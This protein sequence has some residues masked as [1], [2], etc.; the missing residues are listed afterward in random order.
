M[1]DLESV[2]RKRKEASVWDLEKV[3]ACVFDL[4]AILILCLQKVISFFI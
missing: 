1:K 2:A 4:R 3:N